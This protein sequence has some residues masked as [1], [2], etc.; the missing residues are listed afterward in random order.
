MG[1][2]RKVLG[3]LSGLE[4]CSQVTTGSAKGGSQNSTET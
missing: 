3:V 2:D 4:G 1:S